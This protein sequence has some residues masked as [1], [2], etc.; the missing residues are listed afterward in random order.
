MEAAMRCVGT[1][2]FFGDHPHN[3]TCRD[4]GLYLRQPAPDQ[5]ADRAARKFLLQD[6]WTGDRLW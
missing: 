3:Q 4:L 1:M 6:R 5:A 2:A